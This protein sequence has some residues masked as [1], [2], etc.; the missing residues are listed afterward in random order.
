M[1]ELEATVERAKRISQGISVL[2]HARACDG[3]GCDVHGCAAARTLWVH[4]HGCEGCESAV[5]K[6]AKTLLHHYESCNRKRRLSDMDDS[7]D[8]APVC[9]V[10]ALVERERERTSAKSRKRVRFN[11][12]V[13]ERVF[14]CEC[15]LCGTC[16]TRPTVRRRLIPGF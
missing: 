7:A 1:A 16:T 14:E 10:C 6:K 9:L 3:R 8:P 4:L 11:D 13:Q 5:C 12:A 15:Q 2:L